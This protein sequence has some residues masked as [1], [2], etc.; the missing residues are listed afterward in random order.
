[1]APLVKNI[2]QERCEKEELDFNKSDRETVDSI[3][4]NDKLGS[5][6]E[7]EE[8]QFNSNIWEREKSIIKELENEKLLVTI[9][10]FSLISTKNEDKAG[11]LL[12]ILLEME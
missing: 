11:E 7:N 1:M 2:I 4:I 3:S 10:L 8:K 6:N 5:E 12:W 9:E